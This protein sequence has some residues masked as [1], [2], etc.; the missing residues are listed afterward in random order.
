MLF[1]A[2]C[3]LHNFSPQVS[4]KKKDLGHWLAFDG[5]HVM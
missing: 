3:V 1:K 4:I 5:N 2:F